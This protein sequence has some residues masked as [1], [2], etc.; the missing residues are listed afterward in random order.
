MR[1][2]WDGSMLA[3]TLNTKPEKGASSGR[4]TPSTSSRGDGEGTSSTTAS[5]SLRT[6]K[7]VSADPKNT[8][9]RLGG[10]ERLAVELGAGAVEQVDLVECVRPRRALLGRG[11]IGADDLL[12]GLGGA[13][14]DAGEAGEPAVAAVDHAPE[15]AGDADRPR[16][17]RRHEA[18]L[19]LD[20]VEQLDR[21]AARPVPL[22]D[23]AQQRQPALAAHVE[24]LEG[25]GL[26]ALGRV[27]HHDR[28]VGRGQHAVGVLGEVAVA[29]SVEQVHDDLV[30]ATGGRARAVGELQHRRGDRDAALLLER[31]PVRRRRAPPLAGLDRAGLVGERAAVEQE[32][33]GQR[34]LARVGVRDDGEGTA[35][36][37]LGRGCAHLS[38][39]TAARPITGARVAESAPAGSLSRPRR[40]GRARRAPAPGSARPTPRTR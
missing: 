22:V 30:P 18:D 5:S 7:L 19:L 16:D 40:A 13:S 27:E 10:E 2:R 28:G 31:H 21:V 32:L 20:L 17:R 11:P 38:R 9:R 37:G 8:G 23:E 6:P 24:Q 39:V 33:L 25:L 1:S 4:G 14:R 26:D 29:G 35:P 3:C 12:G 36:A 34:G 15:V